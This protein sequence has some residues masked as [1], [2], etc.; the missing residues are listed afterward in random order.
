[1]RRYPH[2]H[3]VVLFLAVPLFGYATTAI[4]EPVPERILIAPTSVGGA[5]PDVAAWRKEFDGR[6]SDGVRRSGRVV[7]LPARGALAGACVEA[8]CARTLVEKEKTDAFVS[9]RVLLSAERPPSY[10]VSVYA[11]DRLRDELRVRDEKCAA[12]SEFQA[13]ELLTRLVAE[14]LEAAPRVIPTPIVPTVANPQQLDPIV[15]KPIVPTGAT[16]AW[17]RP[18]GLSLVLVGGVGLIGSAIG[19]GIK[20][21]Q[22]GDDRCDGHY[23]PGMQCPYFADTT[24]GIAASAVA[25]VLALG[26]GITGVVLLVKAKGH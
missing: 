2:K 5:I 12:C 23:A 10:R 17:M 18:L 16:R 20:A 8:G 19:V 14:A 11:Y 21:A 1:M 4:A 6:L 25:G 9:A 26:V 15:R 7:V 24:P 22:Y 3:A 13:S